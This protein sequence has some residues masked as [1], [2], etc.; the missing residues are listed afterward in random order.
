LR[1]YLLV[2]ILIILICPNI[3]FAE[4]KTIV[5]KSSKIGGYGALDFKGTIV[6]DKMGLLV[7]VSRAVIINHTFSIGGSYTTLSQGISILVDGTVR[8]LHM[9][10]GGI[11][12]G[13]ILFPHVPVHAWI[14]VLLGAGSASYE[15]DALN[16]ENFFLSEP[17]V[18]LEV[19]LAKNVRLSTGV[20]YR[21]VSGIDQLEGFSD[22]M[23][24][25]F[26]VEA[27]IKVGVF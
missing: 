7:G 10:Y 9:G 12:F 5:K 1:K 26:I 19:N 3:L 6:D 21:F 2:T 20:G 13:V 24:S 25:G 17:C 14:K 16:R 27:L 15:F 11:E 4:Q 23:M 22:K 18:Q 8:K